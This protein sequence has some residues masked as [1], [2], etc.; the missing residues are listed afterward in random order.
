MQNEKARLESPFEKIHMLVNKSPQSYYPYLSKLLITHSKD[1]QQL[2][3][4]LQILMKY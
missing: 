2:V 1:Y 3:V 4:G